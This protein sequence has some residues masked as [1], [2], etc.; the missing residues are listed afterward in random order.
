MT[1]DQLDALTRTFSA[2]RLSTYGAHPSITGNRLHG[3][4]LYGWNASL[5]AALMLPL[6]FCEVTV[7]NAISEAITLTYGPDWPWQTNFLLS[8]PVKVGRYRMRQDL[9][10][11]RQGIQQGNTGKVIPELK[12]MFWLQML[13]SRHDG[14]IWIPHI[15]GTFPLAPA[16]LSQSEIR[17]QLSSDL[18]QI[19]KVRNRV[20]HHES[21]LSRNHAQDYVRLQRVVGWRC[22]TTAEWMDLKETFTQILRERP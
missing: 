2:S 22:Q 9:E 10:L 11:A 4:H 14:R 3:M 15:K 19:K 17:S 18:D 1:D 6:H 16:H 7:R 21:I 13:T 5:S 20:A 12:F 8:L